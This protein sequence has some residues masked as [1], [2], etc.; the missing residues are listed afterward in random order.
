MLEAAAILAVAGPAG[1][2]VVLAW[3]RDEVLFAEEREGKKVQ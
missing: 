3:A 2:A 1:L